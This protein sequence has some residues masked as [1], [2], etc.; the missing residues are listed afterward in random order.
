MD[1]F[2]TKTVVITGAGSGFGRGL[3][4][5]FTKLGWKVAVSDINMDRAEETVRLMDGRRPGPGHSM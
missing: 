3:A 5:D 4:M 1:R 2:K